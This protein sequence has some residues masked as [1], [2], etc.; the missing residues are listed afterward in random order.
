MSKK[1]TPAR[2]SRQ[3]HDTGN[4][5]GRRCEPR[6]A[7]PKTPADRRRREQ[8]GSPVQRRVV[9]RASAEIGRRRSGARVGDSTTDFP[10]RIETNENCCCCR[11]YALPAHMHG[12]ALELDF[13]A[14][15]LSGRG[16]SSS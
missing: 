9:G 4:A 7:A 3:T 11:L 15:M 10:L 16:E 5:A 13:I 14:L 1:E 2:R 6:S 12:G 8:R